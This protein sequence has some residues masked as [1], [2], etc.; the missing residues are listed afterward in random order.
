VERETK[1][2][3]NRIIPK[4]RAATLLKLDLATLAGGRPV[5]ASRSASAPEPP[6]TSREPAESASAREQAYVEGVEAGRREAG[7][8]LESER[9]AL[10]ALVAGM[11]ELIQDFEQSLA[12]DVLSMSLELAKLIVR[13]SL[14][15][16]PEV[17]VA[18]VR[19]AVESL[20]GVS[21][22]TVLLVHPEDAALVRKAAES[23]RALGQLPWK[24]VEDG[25]IERGGCRLET[26]TTEVDATLET[27]WRRVLASLGRD[28]PWIDIT[29]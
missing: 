21:D 6:A 2:L 25:H 17:V 13:Q 15:V 12:N 3:S 11:N 7:A 14:R 5:N 24:I 26:P 20:P 19:E 9:A 1:A 22:Q 18:V 16:K 28:D 8:A 23:D 29:I 27:R 10:K 4:E